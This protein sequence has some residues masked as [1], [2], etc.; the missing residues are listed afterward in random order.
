MLFG[1]FTVQFVFN[2]MSKSFLCVLL[3]IRFVCFVVIFIAQHSPQGFFD[4]PGIWARREND[5]G[6]F[7]HI[8]GAASFCF[9]D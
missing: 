3:P 8:A 6:E 7:R 5:P 2:K 1:V 4:A 9:H